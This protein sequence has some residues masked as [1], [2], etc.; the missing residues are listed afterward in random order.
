M[1][2][3]ATLAVVAYRRHVSPHKGFRCAY[4]AAEGRGSCSDIGA[5]LAPRVSLTRFLALMSI[6]AGRCKVAYAVLQSAQNSESELANKER[7]ND[8][9]AESEARRCCGH[10]AVLCFPWP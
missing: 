10:G 2:K 9:D 8:R 7:Q 3:V 5:R 6:Q 1:L 4:A